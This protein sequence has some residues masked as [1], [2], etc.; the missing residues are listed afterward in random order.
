[1]TTPLPERAA[2]NL[3]LAG[4]LAWEESTRTDFSKSSPG[5]KDLTNLPDTIAERLNKKVDVDFRGTPFSEAFAFLSQEISTPIE[6]DGDALKAGG[7]TKN[8]KQTF[9]M[10]SVPAK[11]VVQRIFEESKGISDN[12]E[13]SLVMV[14]NEPQKRIVITTKKNTK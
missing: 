12:P 5:P 3:F 9:Q 10:D 13:K 11:D 2:P 6:I 8:L 4:Y 7:F 1:M 14:V